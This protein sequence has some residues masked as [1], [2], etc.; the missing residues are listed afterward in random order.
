MA[1]YGFLCTPIVVRGKS[2]S[3]HVYSLEEIPCVT[4][5]LSQVCI[6]RGDRCDC[7]GESHNG[8]MTITDQPWFREGDLGE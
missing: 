5:N 3:A 2:V 7:A 8:S 1:S 4:R 6:I